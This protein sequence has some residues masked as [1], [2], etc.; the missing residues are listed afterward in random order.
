M[1]S[2]VRRTLQMK[3]TLTAEMYARLRVLADQLGQAP[4]TVGALFIGDAVRSR[5]AQAGMLPAMASEVMRH[6]GPV[7]E[8]ELGVQMKLAEATPMPDFEL[9]QTKRLAAPKKPAARGKAR[10]SP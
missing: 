2:S 10:R 9:V 4:A 5:E 6:L 1:P 8:R 7:M 3:V